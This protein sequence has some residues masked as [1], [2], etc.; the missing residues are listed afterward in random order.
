M[1]QATT[2]FFHMGYSKVPTM[3][4]IRVMLDMWYQTRNKNFMEFIFQKN[5]GGKFYEM[6]DWFGHRHP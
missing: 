3:N 6:W 2:C 4:L 5:L 1:A